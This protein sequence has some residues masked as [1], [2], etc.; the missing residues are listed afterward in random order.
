MEI[1]FPDQIGDLPLDPITGH[2]TFKAC[3][4]PCPYPDN[5]GV[6]RAS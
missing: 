5:Y 3:R 2:T 1:K 6:F 4:R